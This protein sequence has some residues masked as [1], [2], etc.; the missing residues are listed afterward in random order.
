MGGL[1]KYKQGDSRSMLAYF[2]P[3]IMNLFK[4]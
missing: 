2:Y 4:L 1:K 3:S